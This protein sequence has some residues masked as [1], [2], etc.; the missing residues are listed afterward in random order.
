M[1]QCHLRRE[2]I[3]RRSANEQDKKDR[4]VSSEKGY[5]GAHTC[6]GG[7]DVVVLIDNTQRNR[8]VCNCGHSVV[9]AEAEDSIPLCCEAKLAI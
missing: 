1:D 4:K 6:G 9:K 7:D 8:L 5:Q 2:G 3:R